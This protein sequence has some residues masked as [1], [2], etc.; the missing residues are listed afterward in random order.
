[1]LSGIPVRYQVNHDTQERDAGIPSLPDIPSGISLSKKV[2]KPGLSITL[3]SFN[4]CSL[5]LYPIFVYTLWLGR[6]A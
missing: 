5:T 3:R 4:G 2:W 6:V 1:M